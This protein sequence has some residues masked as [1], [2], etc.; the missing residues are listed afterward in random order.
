MSSL[1]ETFE[2]QL[3][4]QW[5]HRVRYVATLAEGNL[6]SAYKYQAQTGEDLPTP[7]PQSDP[8][9][10]VSGA[11][12]SRGKKGLESGSNLDCWLPISQARLHSL[13]HWRC[14]PQDRLGAVL[15]HQI[16][17]DHHAPSGRKGNREAKNVV[18]MEVYF[19]FLSFKSIWV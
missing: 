19:W 6:R 17:P 3:P 12:G 4:A 13:S 5:R 14:A 1:A 7:P 8:A 10:Q 2:P 16:A 15:S 9:K 18:L 11:E